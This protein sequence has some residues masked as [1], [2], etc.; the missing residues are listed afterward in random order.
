MK[1]C[2][3]LLLS[4]LFQ[5]GDGLAQTILKS[6]LLNQ[7]DS[8]YHVPTL[9]SVNFSSLAVQTE[10]KDPST[11]ARILEDSLKANRLNKVVLKPPFLIGGDVQRLDSI[12][13]LIENAERDRSNFSQILNKDPGSALQG[14]RTRP[15]WN[16]HQSKADSV[17]DIGKRIQKGLWPPQFANSKR[18]LDSLREAS[19]R[20]QQEL[21]KLPALPSSTLKSSLLPYLDSLKSQALNVQKLKVAEEKVFAPLILVKRD[22]QPEWTW[23]TTY[24]IIS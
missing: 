24:P 17:A 2:Y 6:E 23:P 3:W 21:L 5:Y 14:I 13:Q 16:A 11:L 1:S 22:S 18:T 20:V 9:P 15:E 7:A 10:M 12:R 4:I 8:L 19:L